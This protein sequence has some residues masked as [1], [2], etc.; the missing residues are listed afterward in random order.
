MLKSLRVRNL[1]VAENVC[2]EFE[3]GLNVITGE[4]GAGKSILV[5]ALALLLGDRADKTLIRTGEDQCSVEAVFELADSRNAD[6]ILAARDLPPCEDGTLVLRRTI[7]ANG[8]GQAYANDSPVTIQTLR[9][10][11]DALVDLHGPHDHQS[12]FHTSAQMAMLDA[13]GG[14]AV[15]RAAYAEVYDRIRDLERQRSELTIDDVALAREISLLEMTIAEIEG[16]E[17]REGEEEA[18]RREHDIAGHAQRIVELATAATAALTEGEGCAFDQL[19]LAQRPLEELSRLLPAAAE[20]RDEAARLATAVQELGL[21][22]SREGSAVEVDPIRLEWLDQRLAVYQKLRRKYGTDVTAILET[23]RASKERLEDLRSRSER[24]SHIEA[25]LA[26]LQAELRTRGEALRARRRIAAAE[27]SEA[28]TGELEFLGF[29]GSAFAV[30]LAE[31]EPQPDGLDRVEFGFA[32]N[33]GEAMRP[34]RLIAS[35]GEISRLM[36]ALK[37]V[38]A[39]HDRIPVLVFDEIDA[40]LG[41]EMGHAVGR[42]LA[43]VAERHQVLC[44]THLPQVAAHGVAHRVARK[45]VRDGRTY[46]EVAPLDERGRVEE[47]ARMLGGSDSRAAL[48]HAEELLQRT[49]RRRR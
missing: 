23:L 19:A 14:C 24:L 41:G 33:V 3:P 21:A 36:L 20:W 8:S 13:F 22:I 39:E 18:L 15:E 34:L 48:A 16:A 37:A 40:N 45:T 29:P 26:A 1:A 4:T 44:I 42:E 49:H 9:E 32:P 35:S 12:L 5:G 28:V 6:T 2:V 43:G 38:L 10:I 17:L 7:R 46:T 31:T 11:G 47:L 30:D 25:E 27:L